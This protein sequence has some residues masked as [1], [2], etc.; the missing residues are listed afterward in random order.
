M[1]KGIYRLWLSINSSFWLITIY[2]I[3]KEWNC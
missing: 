1:L 2:G 3:Q